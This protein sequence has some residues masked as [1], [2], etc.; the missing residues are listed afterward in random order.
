MGILNTSFYGWHEVSV[1]HV[2][3]QLQSSSLDNIFINGEDIYVT[4]NDASTGLSFG[5]ILKGGVNKKFKE[6][7][8][9]NRLIHGIT[10]DSSGTI[11][12]V[13]GI[14]DGQV[15]SK[16]DGTTFETL[17][18][19]GIFARG[20][21]INV[22]SNDDIFVGYAD[23]VGAEGVLLSSSD[24]GVTWGE[25]TFTS[26]FPIK[27]ALSS[28]DAI[29]ATF[30]NTIDVLSEVASEAGSVA[31]V[32][33]ST[34]AGV[35]WSTVG[36]DVTTSIN[37]NKLGA[38]A[39]G[40]DSAI[41]HVGS[42][43]DA[44]GAWHISIR[45]STDSGDNFTSA[46]FGDGSTDFYGFG[47]D[48]DTNNNVYVGG[49]SG[50]QWCIFESTDGGSTFDILDKKSSNTLITD[51]KIYQGAINH[52]KN[53]IYVS[54]EKDGKTGTLFTG[55]LTANSSSLGPTSLAAS[56]SY[57]SNET[58]TSTEQKFKLMNISEFPHSSGFFQMRNL[59]LGTTDA[60]TIGTSEDN[61]IQVK[62]FGSKVDIMWPKQ[63]DQTIPIRGYADFGVGARAGK[64]VTQF[65][66]GDISNV[67][68][69]DHLALYCYLTK[70]TSGTLDNIEIHVER[71]PLRDT[72]FATEQVLEL[73][74]SGNITVGALRD[75]T[76]RKQ[77]DY[78]D[79]NIKEIGFTIDMPLLNVR[80][81]RVKARQTVGQ[82]DDENRNFI[83]R[84]RFIK[85]EEET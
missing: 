80:Q 13:N 67:E 73:S 54:G 48:V 16:F 14:K 85:S 28:S 81:I 9:T 44:G 50:S 8:G 57:V 17:H 74:S 22:D 20:K 75:M 66:P 78:G 59:V 36:G 26:R 45:K 24:R 3:G 32:K 51:L 2:K 83:I 1:P 58:F 53:R 27:I 5:F 10:L 62:H 71:R 63:S 64:L 11:Y 23:I 30:N 38:I 79:L 34:D 70:E 46:S 4:N 6:I 65:E 18:T 31:H 61:I 43:K 82:S 55:K 41:Y 49:L 39:I 47:V 12:V 76:Y 21:A 19:A 69:F 68:N 7:A 25:Q 33:R 77:I 84:G 40:P 37:E 15:I 72:G 35:T 52:E 42:L 29:F 56:V 60:G